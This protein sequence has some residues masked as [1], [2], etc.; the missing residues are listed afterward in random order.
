MTTPIPVCSQSKDAATL[1]AAQMHQRPP[2]RLSPS[3]QSR[4]IVLDHCTG[5]CLP[6]LE[7]PVV[8]SNDRVQRALDETWREMVYQRDG[9]DTFECQVFKMD[10]TVNFDD[11]DILSVTFFLEDDGGAYP[12]SVHKDITLDTNGERLPAST[13][14][15]ED[16]L[17]HVAALVDHRL[18]EA[19]ANNLS[20][21]SD[22]AKFEEFMQET[23]GEGVH[24]LAQ[25]LEL[26]FVKKDGLVFRFDFGLPHAIQALS[27]SEEYLLRFDELAPYF[28]PNG[29]FGWVTR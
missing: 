13:I 1:T 23:Y 22:R 8:D 21:S 19:V 6:V 5:N 16:A 24:F 9:D 11:H 29:P 4:I 7:V 10:S 25:H 3:V 20:N 12:V 27:P 17:A 2:S 14:F 18:Q 28:D 26:F 15:R